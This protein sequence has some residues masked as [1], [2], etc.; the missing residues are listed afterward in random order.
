MGRGRRAGAAVSGDLVDYRR[1]RDERDHPDR[2]LAGGTREGV[3]L[4]DL[5]EQRRRMAFAHR[6][7]ASV[8]AGRGAGTIAG[9]RSAAAGAALFRL[10][11]G[12]LAYEPS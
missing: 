3:D 2:A 10:P 11:R 1:R 5:L 4:E 7:L 6:R 12:R 8:G 9:G